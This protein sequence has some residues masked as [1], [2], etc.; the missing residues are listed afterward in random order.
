MD[1]PV[2][3]ITNGVLLPEARLKYTLHLLGVSRARIESFALP[4]ASVKQLYTVPG[5]L[6]DEIKVEFLRNLK[7]FLT[8]LT[9]E[10][11]ESAITLKKL[12]EEKNFDALADFSVAQLREVSFSTMLDYLATLDTSRRVLLA[13]EWIKECIKSQSDPNEQ[14]KR[15]HHKELVKLGT[16]IPANDLAKLR[17][18]AQN[19]VRKYGSRV[20]SGNSVE[21][22]EGKLRDAQLPDGIRD[23]AWEE[24]DRLKGMN[25]QQSEY[26]VLLNYLDLVA[27]LPWSKSTPDHIDIS[28]ARQVLDVTHDGMDKVKK[29]VLEFLAVRKLTD[30]ATGPILCF[31][32]PP[33]IGKT[34]IAKAIAKSLGRKFERMSLGGIRDESDIRGHRRTYVAAMPGRIIQAL[35]HAGTNNPV[36]LLDEVDKLYAGVSGSPSAALLEV[37]DP[38]QNNSFVDHYLNLPFDLSNVIFISTANDLSQVEAPLLDRMEV[39]EMSGYSHREKLHIAQNHLLPRQLDK[40]G[41][42]PDH[43]IVNPDAILHMIE[44]YT[45]EAGVRQLERQLGAVCRHGALKLAEALNTDIAADVVPELHLPIVIDRTAV[46]HILG[47]AKF[48]RLNLVKKLGRFKPGMVFGLSVSVLGGKVMPI[49]ATTNPGKGKVQTTGKLGDVLKESIEVAKTWIR[50]NSGRLSCSSLTDIDAHVHI[51]EG[52]VKKDG[53]SAGCAIVSALYSLAANRCVRSDTAVTG[54]ISL[55]GHVLPVGGI[56]EK[57]L[58]AHRAGIRRVILPESN[59][60]DTSELDDTIKA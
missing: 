11:I 31:S 22:L 17:D 10:S 58:G 55:T 36:I 21:A 25:S 35:K 18:K 51:P 46:K 41:I 3:L 32:G 38:E 57:V 53:P 14:L 29:R 1:L 33:G 42:C 16:L 8:Y 30:H 6:N 9:F 2:L 48:E 54:E 20:K 43:L 4:I 44:S 47:I 45:M 15:D 52:A 13:N 23:R 39:I 59:R 19:V 56:K 50:A 27:A 34:S 60:A 49:E 37:L 5:D 40:N 28:K 24:Y 7:D 12:L 26:N